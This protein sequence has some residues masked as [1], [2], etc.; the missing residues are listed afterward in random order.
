MTSKPTISGATDVSGR[1]ERGRASRRRGVSIAAALACF[2][3]FG[4]LAGCGNRQQ[5]QE[6]KPDDFVLKDLGDNGQVLQARADVTS[7]RPLQVQDPVKI[8]SVR[9]SDAAYAS[10]AAGGS[11]AGSSIHTPDEDYIDLADVYWKLN[12]LRKQLV[13]GKVPLNLA[14]ALGKTRKALT[15][16]TRR[17]EN[18]HTAEQAIQALEEGAQHLRADQTL[19]DAH[20][21]R[22]G[23]PWGAGREAVQN[24]LERSGLAGPAGSSL[25][26]ARRPS[27]D[28]DSDDATASRA[29]ALVETPPTL[30]A[31]Q[32]TALTTALTYE[33]QY[34]ASPEQ[35][36][37][38]AWRQ[39]LT[40]TNALRDALQKHP[41]AERH[42]GV[43]NPDVDTG[44]G[45]SEVAPG[46]GETAPDLQGVSGAVPIKSFVPPAP[47][48]SAGLP[49]E[50]ADPFAAPH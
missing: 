13:D 32:Q 5:V 44:D 46:I 24:Y 48:G 23:V 16:V 34:H 2:A 33:E 28:D 37:R 6:N 14:E 42:P 30:T 18:Y 40:L 20:V 31:V 27:H 39:A 4:A 21:S 50:P 41:S 45:Q 11:L 26:P 8:P 19:R 10:G 38:R 47:G 3:A 1:A 12:W 29:H 7:G 9:V 17:D 43:K 22:Y 36:M 15:L 49:P 25:T 35:M